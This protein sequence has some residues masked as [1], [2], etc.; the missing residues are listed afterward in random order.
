MNDQESRGSGLT[1]M[2]FLTERARRAQA[3]HLERSFVPLNS[4][5]LMHFMLGKD[6][7]AT[8]QSCRVELGGTAWGTWV[9]QISIWFQ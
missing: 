7:P 9:D 4:L 8:D 1:L 2:V 6:L 5:E 3:L